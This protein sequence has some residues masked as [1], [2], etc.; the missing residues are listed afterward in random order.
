MLSASLSLSLC[1]SLSALPLSACARI[2]PRLHCSG[3]ETTFI[4]SS[5]LLKAQPAAAGSLLPCPV[6][7]P[8]QR[9]MRAEGVGTLRIVF[10]LNELLWAAAAAAAAPLRSLELCRR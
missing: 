3:H 2:E 5:G 9:T 10:P 7:T 6:S 1:L 8:A 4:V